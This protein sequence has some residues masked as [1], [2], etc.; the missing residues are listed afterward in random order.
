MP[1]Q[2]PSVFPASRPALSGIS[3]QAS[4]KPAPTSASSSSG[5][6]SARLRLW[7]L[8]A[9]CHCPLVGVCLPLEVLRRLAGKALG[10]KVLADAHD[11]HVGVVAQSR[12]R[13][14]LSK[15]LQQELEQRHARVVRNF[16]SASTAEE[17]LQRWQQAVHDGDMAG[18]FWAGLTHRQSNP[19]VRESLCR[20][21]HMLQHQAGAQ[22]RVNRDKMR[23]LQ[24][25]N[26]IL[27]RELGRAQQRCSRMLA[28]K[29]ADNQRLQNEVRQL[30]TEHARQASVMASQA[31]RLL[32]LQQAVPE[33]EARLRLQERLDAMQRRQQQDGDRIR[34][35]QQALAQLRPAQ[36]GQDASPARMADASP[37]AEAPVQ[38]CP[39][40]QQ[41]AGAPLNAASALEQQTVL[42]VGGR[43]ASLSR[44]RALVEQ[45]GGRFAHHDGGL[46][47][48][49]ALLDTSLAAADLVICQ[50]GC[51]SHNAYWRVKDFCKRHGKRC[52]FVAN[53]SVSSLARSLE[54][55]ACLAADKSMDAETP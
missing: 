20:D 15:L 5:K 51:I 11:L 38:P 30:R 24:E 29:S 16:Q 28:E 26:A 10:G 37:P 50:T 21:M 2:E 33:L 7:E 8:P 46:E 39:P 47:H 49:C 42:C 52:V 22:V 3:R 35:L 43:H 36:A 41:E 48:N 12:C 9:A 6:S 4:C 17:V 55:V 34:Q 13:N 54:Q 25:E 14:R 45:T 1:V 31:S 18:G 32:A 53:P 44:Y 27:A 40:C 19:M 23:A